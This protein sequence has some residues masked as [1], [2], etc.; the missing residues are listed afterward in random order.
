MTDVVTYSLKN[1]QRTSDQFY[2][3]VTTFTDRVI[4]GAT[5]LHP[6]VERYQ[7][8]LKASGKEAVRSRD[9]YLFEL[10]LLGTLWRTYADDAH[11]VSGGWTWIM[12]GLA[13]LRQRGGVVKEVAD[14]ARGIMATL[15]LSPVDREW[16][17][18]PTQDHLNKLLNWMAATGDYVQETRRL[19]QWRDYWADLSSEEV[20]ADLTAAIGFAGWF[21][22]HSRAALGKYTTNVDRFLREQQ[23]GHR[24]KEDVIFSARRRVEY[25]LNMVGAEIMNRAFRADFLNAKNKAVVLPACMRYYPKPQCK[26]RSNGVSCECAEC[27]SQCRVNQLVKMGRKF[28]FSVH[29]V[30]HESSVLSNKGGKK[31]FGDD[32]GILGIACVSNLISG[33]WKVKS[34][35]IAPQCVLL[36]HCGCR[37]HWHEQ[38]IATDINMGRLMEILAIKTTIPMEMIQQSG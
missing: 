10:A 33:G 27:A 36:D 17:P 1:G 18:R 25:H 19:G 20:A 14:R 22:E 35:G 29:L 32:V 31:L 8:Y 34:F 9:E 38:G 26:A 28:G 12:A 21:E 6:V 23:P 37:K 2:R 24:W 15:F 30:P 4:A 3:D 7:A 16:T 11:E 13:W 5:V